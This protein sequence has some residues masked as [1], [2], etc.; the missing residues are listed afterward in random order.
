MENVIQHQLKIQFPALC[1][2]ATLELASCIKIKNN[3][4]FAREAVQKLENANILEHQTHFL[5]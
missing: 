1:I 3:S 5:K 4:A 2:I